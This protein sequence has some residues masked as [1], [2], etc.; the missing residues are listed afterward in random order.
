MI[1][2]NQSEQFSTAVSI[3]RKEISPDSANVIRFSIERNQ[4]FEIILQ[5]VGFGVA[6]RNL[7][8]RNGILW[9]EVAICSTWLDILKEAIKTAHS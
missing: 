1:T 7:L 5:Q 4:S 2:M 9:E 3:L 8:A 6:L